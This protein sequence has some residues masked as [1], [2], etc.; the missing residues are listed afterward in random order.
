M[1]LLLIL[2]ALTSQYLIFAQLINVTSNSSVWPVSS[3]V[4]RILLDQDPYIKELLDFGVVQLID[5]GK[6]EGQLN[7]DATYELSWVGV[8][9][10]SQGV[11]T[12]ILYDIKLSSEGL[13]D[14]RGIVRVLDNP[15]TSSRN[16]TLID[17]NTSSH[18]S[19]TEINDL[20]LTFPFSYVAAQIDH[21]NDNIRVL[22]LLN[23]GI[24]SAFQEAV[25]A[26]TLTNANYD[27]VGLNNVAYDVRDGVTTYF[28]RAYINV[29][30][31]LTDPSD[32]FGA[33]YVVVKEDNGENPAELQYYNLF[34]HL[35]L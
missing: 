2:F 12:Q 8:I 1:R 13:D 15:E 7:A 17:I 25:T 3:F 4:P 26:G 29:Y 24:S 33:M 5:Q 34:S 6:T 18:Q 28:F 21:I 20:G 35:S 11:Q 14:V 27:I 9:Q 23:F 32:T 22:T 19:A 10:A 31:L 30:G 16:V